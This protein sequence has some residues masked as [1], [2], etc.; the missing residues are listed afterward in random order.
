[1]ARTSPDTDPDLVKLQTLQESTLTETVIVPLLRAMN[2]QGIRPQ[3]GPSENGKDL[4][5]WHAEPFGRKEWY[6]C[7]VKGGHLTGK[8]GGSD[9]FRT[10]ANQLQ[11]AADTPFTD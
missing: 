9:S 8:A 4:V 1:M 7:Q 3:H 11:Q 5:F 2:F 10:V 6:G